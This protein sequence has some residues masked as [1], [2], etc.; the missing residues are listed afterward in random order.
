MSTTTYSAEADTQRVVPQ[1]KDSG[2]HDRKDELST[3]DALKALETEANIRVPMGLTSGELTI[4]LDTPVPPAALSATAQVNSLPITDEDLIRSKLANPTTTN[5]LQETDYEPT[6]EDT[7]KSQVNPEKKRGVVLHPAVETDSIRRALDEFYPEGSLPVPLFAVIEDTQFL[8]LELLVSDQL[9]N[10]D[11]QKVKF[12]RAFLELNETLGLTVNK[13]GS[14]FPDSELYR[15]LRD[16]APKSDFY[17]LLARPANIYHRT[18]IFWY[19]Y[20][21]VGRAPAFK[22]VKDCANLMAEATKEQPTNQSKENQPVEV[23]LIASWLREQKYSGSNMHSIAFFDMGMLPSY[24][25]LIFPKLLSKSYEYE[26]SKKLAWK[27]ITAFAETHAFKVEE[28]KSNF[29][30][31]DYWQRLKAELMLIKPQV[32]WNQPTTTLL[33]ELAAPRN[34]DIRAI[35]IILTYRM[36]GAVEASK[37]VHAIALKVDAYLRSDE[38]GVRP[39]EAFGQDSDAE[40]LYKLLRV[41]FS[42]MFYSLEAANSG[43]GSMSNWDAVFNFP[44]QSYERRKFGIDTIDK[45]TVRAIHAML[46]DKFAFGPEPRELAYAITHH[47]DTFDISIINSEIQAKYKISHSTTLGELLRI[48]HGVIMDRQKK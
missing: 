12:L 26:S 11:P 47:K 10:T 41:P 18:Y 29:A 31:S 28:G 48:L 30:S 32:E 23:G 3:G 34:E 20:R 44:T 39:K 42:Y 2:S 37:L 46:A 8:L 5:F 15:Q 36:V 7:A 40:K 38:I 19:I 45:H 14:N 9:E 25:G 16:G 43:H 24:D 33:S 17:S 13:E 27:S 6:F 1:R 4:S 22:F 21:F 35:A